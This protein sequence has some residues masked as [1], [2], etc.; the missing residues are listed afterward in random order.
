MR[1]EALVII[2]SIA[3][4]GLIAM[5]TAKKQHNQDIMPGCLTPH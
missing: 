3:A 4:T 1:D 5:Q 2:V